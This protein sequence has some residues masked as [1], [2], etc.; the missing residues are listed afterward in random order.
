MVRRTRATDAAL[1][2]RLLH[3]E[4]LIDLQVGISP[5]AGKSLCG[6]VRTVREELERRAESLARV[7]ARVYGR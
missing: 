3:L 1:A 4:L 6:R 7:R 5:S 2:K